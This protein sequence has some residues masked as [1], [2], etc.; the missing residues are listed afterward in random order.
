[1]VDPGASDPSATYVFNPESGRV[2]VATIRGLQ[3]DNYTVANE[4]YGATRRYG[5]FLAIELLEL[6]NFP[7]AREVYSSYRQNYDP[8]EID[9]FDFLWASKLAGQGQ[10]DQAL[11][12]ARTKMQE[13]SNPW[14][15]AYFQY[16]QGELLLNDG[17]PKAAMPHLEQALELAPDDDTARLVEGYSHL[18]L[19]LS[20]LQLG[21]PD[22]RLRAR[23]HFMVLANRHPDPQVK[24]R[25]LK[26]IVSLSQE[27]GNDRTL[28]RAY[29][30]LIE[31]GS[32]S[33][34]GRS[35]IDRLEHRM[36]HL[37]P[38]SV[39]FEL[40]W[41]E[42]TIAD[43]AQQQRIRLLKADHLLNQG[44]RGEAEQILEELQGRTDH[45]A[46]SSRAKARLN[47]LRSSRG[48]N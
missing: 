27:E 7:A 22:N 16:L 28:E 38:D 24:R 32:P 3:A 23:G 46:A 9:D 4:T 14:R 13:A 31:T 1:V 42:G 6:D 33:Q 18:A 2:D 30:R 40:Q 39:D 15:R 41:L 48:G 47:S 25:A 8:V 36:R 45:P 10:L 11:D 29:G 34:R 26:S 44:R 12:F 35:R 20:H 5:Y 19:A 37:P 43:E 17:Q 21:G